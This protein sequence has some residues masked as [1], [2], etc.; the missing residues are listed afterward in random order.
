MSTSSKAILWDNDGVLVDTEHLFFEANREILAPL[1][2]ELT[3]RMFLDWY[4]LDNCGAWHLLYGRGYGPADIPALRQQRNQIQTR[5]LRERLA[6]NSQLAIPGMPQL[7]AQ[8]ASCARM[9]VVTSAIRE[10][11]DLI[12]ADLPFKQHIEFALTD[13]CYVN[14]K[15]APDPYLAGLARLKMPARD[16]LAVEDSPRGLLAARAAGLRCVV[17]QSAL[18]LDYTFPGAY[19]VARDVTEL[20]N[21]LQDVLRA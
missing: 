5:L 13:E 18:T 10:H 8:L 2:V 7:V 1:G 6:Q 11:F 4:L 21:I 9:G 20:G 16:C 3:P 15:P 17:L 12:H 19:A 14:S